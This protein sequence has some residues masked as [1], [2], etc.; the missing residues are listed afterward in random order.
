[1]RQNYSWGNVSYN[2]KLMNGTVKSFKNSNCFTQLRDYKSNSEIDTVT[3]DNIKCKP[4]KKY[5]ELYLKYISEMLELEKVEIT[6]NSFTFGAFH[7]SYKNLLVC[8]LVRFLFE[9]IGAIIPAIPLHDVFF[10][11]LLIDGEC[12][13]NDKLERFCYFY[14]LIPV[15][16]DYFHTG[17]SWKPYQTKIKSLESFKLFNFT[18]NTGVNGFFTT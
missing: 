5:I 17:H 6:D 3:I 16:D 14:K 9:N 12:K 1:M 7:S 15:K 10:K 13:Y 8:S 2:F 11:P 18:Y 4:S